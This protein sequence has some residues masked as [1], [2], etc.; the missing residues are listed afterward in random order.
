M[1]VVRVGMIAAAIF[2]V[3]LAAWAQTR[4]FSGTWTRDPSSAPAGDGEGSALGNGPATVKQT[5]ETLTI[6]RTMG[7]DTVTLPTNSMALA[8][9]TRSRAATAGRSI[10]SRASNG[11]APR[12]RLSPSRK[13]TVSSRRLPKC[14]PSSARR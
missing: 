8:A 12:S 11:T 6:Q 2:A 7:G 4:D 3:A 1:K 10:R 14:G 9:G 5:A 13:V